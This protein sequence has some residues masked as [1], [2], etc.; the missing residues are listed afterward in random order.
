[1]HRNV[2]EVVYWKT[3]LALEIS[4]VFYSLKKKVSKCKFSSGLFS[5]I[6]LIINNVK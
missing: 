3:S 2:P 6:M 5:L 1:M 4:N